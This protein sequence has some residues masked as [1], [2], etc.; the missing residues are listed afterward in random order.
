VTDAPDPEDATAWAAVAREIERDI[1]RIDAELD[2]L[3][4]RCDGFL[5]STLLTRRAMLAADLQSARRACV[6]RP[7]L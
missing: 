4:F 5:R 7:P 1:K 3:G 6:P 2:E